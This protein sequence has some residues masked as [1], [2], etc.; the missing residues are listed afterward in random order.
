MTNITTSELKFIYFA[1]ILIAVVG[2][3]SALY[4]AEPITE[5]VQYTSDTSYQNATTATETSWISSLLSIFPAPF[6]DPDILIVTAI[7]IAPISF[8]MAPI[9]IRYAKDIVTQWL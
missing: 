9:A 2:V 7:F 1:V 6:D 8:M 5:T 4:A 3:F